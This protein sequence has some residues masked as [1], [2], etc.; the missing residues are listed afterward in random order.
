MAVEGELTMSRKERDRLKVVEAVREKRLKQ[1]EAAQQLGLSVRQVKRLV[2][3]HREEGAAG[4]VS[5]RR[6]QPSN[7]RIEDAEREE[8]MACVR[9]RYGDF[10]PTL[11]A[12]YLRSFHGFTRSTETLRQWMIEA[13]A[14]APKRQRR[15]RPFQLRERRSCIGELVQIDGSP[16]AWL[17][18]RGPRCTL[19]A[20]I[21]DATSRLQYARFEPAETT[22]AYLSGL[23][24]YVTRF[25][26][27]V[28]LYSDRHSIFTKHDPENPTPTQFERAARALTIEP[29]LALSPQAKGRV[30]RAF[31]TLQDRLVKALRLAGIDTVTAANAWLPGFIEHYNA[32]FGKA[33]KSSQDAHRA[34]EVDAESLRWMTS[35]QHPRTLSKSLSCQYQGRQ[36]LIQTQG[37]PAYHLRAARIIVCDDGSDDAIVLLH[38][39]RPLPYRVF[40]RHDLPP[41]IADDKTVDACVEA[42]LQRQ[43]PPR[44]NP[45]PDHPWR[46]AFNAVAVARA[47]AARSGGQGSPP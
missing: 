16:H 15:K 18:A 31:Q 8:V 19:I 23:R 44:P 26:R 7:R 13:D 29:I 4:L 27:P 35:E 42:A 36:Y 1:G 45:P 10:G 25:G 33:P 46:K 28:A 43:A 11:A 22:R 30:E 39:G 6:G 24:A 37:A 40:A 9:S 14:W 32:R 5:Q 3:A 20:F 2:R 38:Q 12:E 17:E 41:R 21:D 34:L 47:L